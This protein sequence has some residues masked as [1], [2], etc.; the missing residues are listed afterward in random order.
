MSNLMSSKAEN[1]K[2]SGSGKA[3]KNDMNDSK[4]FSASGFTGNSL[5]LPSSKP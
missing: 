1:T 5:G 4:V 3:V 2:N